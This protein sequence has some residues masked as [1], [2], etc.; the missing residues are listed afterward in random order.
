MN[1]H[2]DCLRLLV[3]NGAD[4]HAKQTVCDLENTNRVDT[5]Y[6]LSKSNITVVFLEILQNIVALAI[7]LL[8]SSIVLTPFANNVVSIL[9]F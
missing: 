4:V 8:S 6:L 1:A 2:A 7:F 5:P 3:A 9:F